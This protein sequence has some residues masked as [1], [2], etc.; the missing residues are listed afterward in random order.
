MR[1][2]LEAVQVKAQELNDYVNAQFEKVQAAQVRAEAE[3]Q[4][5][6]GTVNEWKTKLEAKQLEL[7]SEQKANDQYDNCRKG[8]GKG[9][10]ISCLPA[11]NYFSK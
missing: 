4:R 11:I 10:S 2:M 9:Q 7:E 8:C 3:I 1:E 5:W 6:N